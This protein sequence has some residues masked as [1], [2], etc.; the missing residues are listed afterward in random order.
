MRSWAQARESLG[1]AAGGWRRCS[2][3]SAPQQ[4]SHLEQRFAEDN[5]KFAK[6]QL[7]GS[8]EERHKRRVKRI[9]E[10]LEDWWGARRGAA[11]RVRQYSERAP[12]YAELR[13]RDRKRRQA[14]V[15]AMVRAREAK[16]RLPALG[17]ELGTRPRRRPTSPR[18]ARARREYNAAA[19]RPRPDAER[20]AAR[21]RRGAPAPLR[22]GLRFCA[23]RGRRLTTNERSGP[24]RAARGPLGAAAGELRRAH[25]RHAAR[26]QG[27]PRQRLDRHR[28]HARPQASC[29]ATRSSPRCS[30]GARTS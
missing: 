30:A 12:F 24:A 29:C 21:A 2:T 8:K 10:R 17:G 5:R 23:P 16:K 25:A 14:R 9:E 20:R 15:L 27:A 13:D 19:A 22:R 4:I 26:V 3:G 6:E 1:A 7:R 18:A 28:L 11:E